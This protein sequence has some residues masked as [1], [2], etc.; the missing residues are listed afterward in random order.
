MDWDGLGWTFCEMELQ[1]GYTV[2][3]SWKTSG[4]KTSKIHE[5]MSY[6]CWFRNPARKTTWHLYNVVNN[7]IFIISTGD[8][9]ISEPSTVSFHGWVVFMQPSLSQLGALKIRCIFRE[10]CSIWQHGSGRATYFL[11]NW[12][13]PPKIC[14]YLYIYIYYSSLVFV[15]EHLITC[16]C[17]I[18]NHL[19]Q[20]G[21]SFPSSKLP[22]KA[23]IRS[24]RQDSVMVDGRMDDI[25][26]REAGGVERVVPHS[27]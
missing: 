3:D 6:C 2:Y 4:E 21:Q 15:F 27:I 23:P 25:V 5:I 14:V 12:E 26:S 8:G 16:V 20:I 24:Q 7:G 17:L 1:I 18:E 13:T 22:K 9:R 19:A 11:G 10:L